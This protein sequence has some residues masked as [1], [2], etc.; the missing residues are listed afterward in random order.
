M[1]QER[2]NGAQVVIASVARTPIGSFQGALSSR[3]APELG[4]IAIEAALKR[5]GLD[6]TA[7]A[8]VGEVF[9]GCVLGAGLGQ[10]PARQAAHG[11]GLPRSVGAVTVNKVCG[12]GLKSI[13]LGAQSIATGEHEIVVAGGMESMSNA[14][15]LLPEARGGMRMGNRSAVDSMVHDGLWDPYGDKHMGQCGELCARDKNISREAQDAFAA[16]SYKRALQAQAQGKFISEIVPVSVPQRRGEPIVVSEDEEPGRGKPDK[17]SKLRPAFD[18]DGSITAG[19]ASSINDGAAAVVLMAQET[20]IQRNCRPLARI[21]GYQVHAQ[22]PD[23]LTTAPTGAI[24]KLLNKIGW[25]KDS[26]DLWEINEAYAVVTLA[27]NQNLG[28]DGDKVNVPG[29][30]FALGHP[31]GASGTRILV[32][33]LAALADRKGKRGIASLCIGGGEGIAMAVE[34]I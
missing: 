30:A 32:T 3:A 18:K 20:A 19:N 27:N 33:L 16:Q 1:A 6:G 13:A 8:A 21:V 9:M 29:G 5:A 34:L 24:E 26:V 7:G 11:A 25:E 31:I 23:W 22:D 14:P 4:A 10:A 15:Y 28:L 12:S 2:S 17:L